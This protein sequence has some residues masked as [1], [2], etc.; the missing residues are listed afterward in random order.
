M[1]Y[2]ESLK[3]IDLSYSKKLVQMPEFSSLSNLEGLILKGC[4]RLI[5]IHPSVGDLKKLTTLN[6]RR[7]HKLKGLPSS[8]SNLE[9]LEFLDLS[10]CSSF[11]NWDLYPCGRSNL[12]KCLVNQRNMRSLRHLYLCKTAIRELPSNIDLE[13]VEILDLFNCF[14]FKKF[15]EN[16]AK[17]KSL[18]RLVLTNTGI[19]EL[20]T[21][22]A[23]RNL[24]GGLI[25]LIAQSLRNFR[26]REGT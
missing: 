17:M 21:G 14:K 25:S 26:R 2:L 19:K 1:Q 3:V 23:N 12:E 8:I 10:G 5:D 18:Q 6:L 22:I 15:S 4:V 7:C 11:C 9:S 24:L 13:S 16:G 20:P